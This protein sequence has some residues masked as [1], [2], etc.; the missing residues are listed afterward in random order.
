MSSEMP[1]IGTPDGTA[2]GR[3]RVGSGMAALDLM[4]AM[5]TAVD[6]VVR[7]APAEVL[8][9]RPA[10]EEW[11]PR[12]VVAHLLHVE[13]L[14]QERLGAMIADPHD[15]PMPRVAPAPPPGMALDSLAQWRAERAR[16]LAWLNTLGPAELERAGISPRFGRITAREQV[17]EWA[18]H[19]LDHLRQLLAAIE[20]SLYPSIGGYRALYPAP[21]PSAPGE[22]A[23][24]TANDGAP[25]TPAG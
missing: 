17:V 15:A 12:E 6:A 20:T 2:R 8:E 1:S 9:R 3:A 14:L 4:R 7:S 25:R 10:P 5:R 22:T 21:F 16:T 19:D 11:S 24:A 18:Y 23:S 13:R